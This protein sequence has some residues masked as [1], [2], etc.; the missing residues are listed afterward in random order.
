[1]HIAVYF[2]LEKGGALEQVILTCKNLSKNNELDIY[3]HNKNNIDILLKNNIY[4]Y[5]IN[6]DNK[7][8]WSKLKIIKK[9]QHEI[10][11]DINKKNYDLILVFP[12][13]FIQSPYLLRYLPS[14]KTIYF[15]TESKREFYEETSFKHN[16][17]KNKLFRLLSYK[18]KI[19]DKINCQSVQNIIS[20]S[21]YTKKI[22][23]KIYNKKSF[24]LYP[25]LSTKVIKEYIIYAPY[26][27]LSIGQHNYIKGHDLTIKNFSNKVNILGRKSHDSDILY[28]LNSNKNVSFIYTENDEEKNR[29]INNHN[30]FL[31]NY[32]N[33]PFGI[34]TLEASSKNLL[35]IGLNSGGTTEII[36]HG[37]NGYLYPLNKISNNKLKKIKQKQIKF[38]NYN[39]I[40]WD[41]Y[42]TKLNN[43]IN[44]ITNKPND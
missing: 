42:S 29:I 40:D 34:S 30:I 7:N 14:R 18:Y 8:L 41:Q 15:F 24:V 39:K 10:S 23:E 32:R 9:I 2:N 20:N 16:S 25:G 35:V 6:T 1:M 28:K 31:A 12:C 36:R 5:K 22:L 27:L 13:K 26:K 11:K 4:E 33:E 44:Y 21:I 19:E 3:C 17:F 43:I 37:L 38:I